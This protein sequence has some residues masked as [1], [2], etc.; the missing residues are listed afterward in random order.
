MEDALGE[1]LHHVSD[2]SSYCKSDEKIRHSDISDYGNL[3]PAAK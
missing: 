2:K 1:I 3:F